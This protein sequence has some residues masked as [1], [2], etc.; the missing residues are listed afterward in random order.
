M[1]KWSNTYFESHFARWFK[2][3]QKQVATREDSCSIFI[4]KQLKYIRIALINK[5]HS[6][7]STLCFIDM[8]NGDLYTPRKTD[9][10]KVSSK[11]CG[12]LYHKSGLSCVTPYGLKKA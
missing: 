10:Y 8:R 3:A 11:C 1:N 2:Y 4:D 7:H 5:E 6:S 9:H 12:N